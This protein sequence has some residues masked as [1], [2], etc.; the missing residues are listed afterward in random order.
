VFQSCFPDLHFHFFISRFSFFIDCCPMLPSI[1]EQLKHLGLRDGDWLGVLGDVRSTPGRAVDDAAIDRLIAALVAAVGETGHVLVPTF[2][3]SAEFHEDTTPAAT[4]RLAER[5][6]RWPG[7]VR[8]RHPTHSVAVSGPRTIDIIRDHDLYLPFLPETPLGQLGRSGG[9]ALLFGGDMKANALI[10]AGRVSVTRERPVI[11]FNVSHVLEFGGHR[12]KRHVEQPCSR[13]FDA[14][15]PE[16]E[17]RGI[18]RPIE[19]E[20]GPA[21]WMDAH[22]VYEYAASIERD[23]PK[24]LLCHEETCRWC[25]AMEE[26]LV[27]GTN[28]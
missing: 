20:W 3:L 6:R 8:S 19:T 28:E 26:M 21:T 23:A 27:N 1:D 5:F 12:R 17:S 18:A 11:W 14:L 16:M 9:W 13:A 25:R 22:A 7:V 4:G 15:G 24:R 2:T 10:Q